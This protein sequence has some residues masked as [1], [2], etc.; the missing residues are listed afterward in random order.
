MLAETGCAGVSIGRGAFY[1]PWIFAHTR[2]YLDTGVLPAEASFD[3]RVRVMTRHLERYIAFYGD[4]KGAVLFR[5]VAP[6]YAKR[7]GP[8]REFKRHIVTAQPSRLRQRARALREWR[9]Q[10]LATTATARQVP[11]EAARAFV[12]APRGRGSAE[13]ESIPVPKARGDQSGALTSA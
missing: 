9:A 6:W 1:N 4:E 3:E 13:R 5:K 11:A 8:S 2:R 10:F 7:F 12:P